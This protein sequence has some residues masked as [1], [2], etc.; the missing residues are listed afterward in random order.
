MI[1]RIKARAGREAGSAFP[2]PPSSLASCPPALPGNESAEEEGGK[3]GKTSLLEI[4]LSITNVGRPA[5][6]ELPS[7]LRGMCSLLC[8]AVKPNTHILFTRPCAPF[9][10]R[11]RPVKSPCR[12]PCFF[13]SSIY[14]CPLFEFPL[15]VPVYLYTFPSFAGPCGSP[16]GPTWP[17]LQR[18]KG[19]RAASP[20]PA[21]WESPRGAI[22]LSPSGIS[23]SPGVLLQG[24]NTIVIEL[25]E[26]PLAAWS[27]G[28]D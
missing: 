25:G 14:A 28:A 5:C 23:S 19:C 17:H 27:R 6:W 22:Q 12:F 13:A 21:Q 16:D 10:S 26:H 11:S 3:S 2:L 24:F 15:P 20:E 8:I 1:S 4:A 7:A 18:I 9:M